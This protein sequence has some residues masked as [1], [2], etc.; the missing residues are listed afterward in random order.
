MPTSIAN[1]SLQDVLVFNPPY[2]PTPKSEMFSSGIEAAWAGGD[3]GREVLDRLLPLI[4]VIL[5]SFLYCTNIN[6]K[7]GNEI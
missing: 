3:R 7:G 1:N 4:G 5:I 6:N 2:V